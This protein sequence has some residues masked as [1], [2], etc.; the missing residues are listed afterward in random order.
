MTYDINLC[1]K[2]VFLNYLMRENDPETIPEALKIASR[3]YRFSEEEKA[4]ALP[5][6]RCLKPLWW[7]AIQ[8]LKNSV[9]DPNA[10]RLCLDRAEN[11]LTKEI[12]FSA[13]MN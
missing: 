10:I 7:S 13:F 5:L 11:S 2:D 3:F 8:D 9:N 12:D 1:G 6:Y 4:A